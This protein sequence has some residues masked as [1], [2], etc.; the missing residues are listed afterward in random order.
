MYTTIVHR[1]KVYNQGNTDGLRDTF[2]DAVFKVFP[3]SDEFLDIL[4][5]YENDV[6]YFVSTNGDGENIILNYSTGEWVSWY[7]LT[8]IGRC[9]VSTCAP[10]RFVDFLKEFKE[11]CENE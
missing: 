11:K 5:N 6:D 4:E 1:I 2:R 10:E 3:K 8:H 7:K 9:L